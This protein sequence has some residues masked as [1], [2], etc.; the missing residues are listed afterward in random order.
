VTRGLLLAAVL[1]LTVATGV[2]IL[3]AVAGVIHALTV[4]AWWGTARQLRRLRGERPAS[5]P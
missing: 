4:A 5:P 2:T 3:L 1:L